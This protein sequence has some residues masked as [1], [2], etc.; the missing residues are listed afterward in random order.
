MIACWSGFERI[1]V[2]SIGGK[3]FEIATG[4]EHN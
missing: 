1:D 3:E 4:S 2:E